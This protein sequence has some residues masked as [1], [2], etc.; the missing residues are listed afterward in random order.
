[1]PKVRQFWSSKRHFIPQ[2]H[3][4]WADKESRFFLLL[5]GNL[6]PDASVQECS[7]IGNLCRYPKNGCTSLP[8]LSIIR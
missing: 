1:M 2:G 6:L 3:L 8:V 4:P 5:I 7:E